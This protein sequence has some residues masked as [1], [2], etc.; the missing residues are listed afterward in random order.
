MN[1][2]ADKIDKNELCG[3]PGYPH[4]L[5]LANCKLEDASNGD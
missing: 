2:L 4:W 1:T 3:Y 5:V